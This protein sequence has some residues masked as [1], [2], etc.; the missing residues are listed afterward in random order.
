M[1]MQTLRGWDDHKENTGGEC[2][3]RRYSSIPWHCC[4]KLPG[5]EVNGGR[6]LAHEAHLH[7]YLV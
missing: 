1:T 5:L 3:A 2:L 6:I 4:L 7:T